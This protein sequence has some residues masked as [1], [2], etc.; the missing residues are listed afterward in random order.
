MITE[1]V[2]KNR[3]NP[4]SVLVKQNNVALDFSTI[5]RMVL[6]FGGNNAIADSDVNS[7][8]INWFDNGVVEFNIGGLDI[9][10]AAPLSATLI[11]YDPSHSDGQV[12]THFES[13]ELNFRF[14]IT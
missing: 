13:N 12:I 6:S 9:T 4:N 10:T 2:Y 11:A 7:D 8:F 1:I 3:D 5:T 14:V